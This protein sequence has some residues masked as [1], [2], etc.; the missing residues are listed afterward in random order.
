MTKSSSGYQSVVYIVV[1]NW[2]G[3]VDTISCL[4]SILRL[5]YNSFRVILIDNG[6]TDDSIDWIKSWADGYLT[7][8]SKANHPLDNLIHPPVPKPVPYIVMQEEDLLCYPKRDETLPPLVLVRSTRNL[9]FA[10]GCNIGLNFGFKSGADYVWLLNNDTVVEPSALIGLVKTAKHNNNDVLVGSFIYEFNNPQQMQT[11][12][13]GEILWSRARCRNLR[14]SDKEGLA[15][16]AGTSLLIPLTVYQAIEG[17]DAE[18]YFYWEDVD[19]SRRAFAAGFGLEVSPCGIVYHRGGA[20]FKGRPDRH[21][22]IFSDVHSTKGRCLFFSKWGKSPY[23]Q[24][25][26][27]AH[28]VGLMAKRCIQGKVGRIW[29]ILNSAVRG[30]RDGLSGRGDAQ[31]K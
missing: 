19:Y 28:V 22:N 7:T 23:W 6:S 25:A 29:E 20:R 5:E 26:L 3:W 13:G 17:L 24:I 12:G 14:G 10:G 21:R 2:N 11:Y 27:T 9:G 31:W 8:Q 16:I 18:Y 15:Y 30:V 1:L 4:E